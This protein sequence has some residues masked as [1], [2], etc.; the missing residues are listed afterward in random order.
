MQETAIQNES[1]IIER[2]THASAAGAEPENNLPVVPE[3]ISQ[4]LRASFKRI[5]HSRPWLKLARGL[6]R[7]LPD[8]LYLALGYLLYFGKWPNYNNPRTFS[9]HTQAYMLKC[10]D[11]ILHIAADKAATR[12]YVAK[13]AGSQYLM[14]CLGVWDDTDE[15]PIASFTVPVVL[16][17]TVGSGMV[18][19]VDPRKKVNVTGVRAILKKWLSYDYSGLHREWAYHGLPR[20]VIVEPALFDSQGNI[21]ADYKA[22]VIGGKVRLIQVDRGRFGCH[23]RN[24]YSREWE[25]LKARLT[26][27][28]HALD[29]RPAKLDELVKVAEQL[30]EPFEFLRVDFF[31]S[32]D[33]LYVVELTNYS[34][35]GF[36]RFIPASFDLE[37][38]QHWM[39]K[40]S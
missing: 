20:K 16:K 22:Y 28:N 8:R 17:A 18:L 19:F 10:R 7:P 1:Q 3:N 39:P 27:N 9:E 31:V 35:A 34:G 32:D 29:D 40:S 30:A 21:P 25:P 4:R 2:I 14:P 33:W 11:P 24:L 13:F 12:D 6:G 5:V 23:T 37:L 36:E 26:L 15:I 38:G